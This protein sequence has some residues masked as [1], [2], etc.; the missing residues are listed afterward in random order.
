MKCRV[1][2]ATALS[3]L[4]FGLLHYCEQ[5]NCGKAVFAIAPV[6]WCKSIFVVDTSPTAT[7]ADVGANCNIRRL[8]ERSSTDWI[9]FL[10]F[11]PCFFSFPT[12]T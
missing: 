11:Q 9:A 2:H 8:L 6:D 7:Y 12:K 4:G 3:L 1:S 5:R 10:I